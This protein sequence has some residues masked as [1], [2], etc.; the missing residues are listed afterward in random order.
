M[1]NM[2]CLW[3]IGTRIHDPIGRGAFLALYLSSGV[4]GAF[5]TWSV[6]VL[7]NKLATNALGASGAICGILAALL[8]INRD[9]E[10]ALWFLPE[11]WKSWSK[12]SGWSWWLGLIGLELF[13]MGM[14]R[15]RLKRVDLRVDHVGHLG[16]YLMGFVGGWLLSMNGTVRGGG[17]EVRSWRGMVSVEGDG[18]EKEKKGG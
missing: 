13:T 14:G 7:R 18:K 10:M 1:Q 17:K 16:G 4:F 15:F 9:E 2:L 6:A 12:M 8:A 5:S 3:L 11:E